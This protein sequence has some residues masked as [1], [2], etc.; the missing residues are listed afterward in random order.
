MHNGAAIS[1]DDNDID[2]GV[3]VGMCM[4][5]VVSESEIPAPHGS[6]HVALPCRS[7]RLVFVVWRSNGIC[8]MIRLFRTTTTTSMQVQV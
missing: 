3:Y 1:D 6:F 7:R 2:A 4:P 8:T 5:V